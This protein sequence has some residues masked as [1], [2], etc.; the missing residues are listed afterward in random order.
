MWSLKPTVRSTVGLKLQFSKGD[1][2][3]IEFGKISSCFNAG[4][5]Q[6]SHKVDDIRSMYATRTHATRKEVVGASSEECHLLD[7]AHRKGVVGILEKH[8]AL[9]SSLT[10]DG[11]MSL[12]IRSIRRLIAS[13]MRSLDDVFQH[14]AN[15]LIHILNL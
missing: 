7:I 10:G 11:S 13:K 2:L 6:S 3:L 12:E 8:H 4:I 14:S 9:G 15:A 1:V 5:L